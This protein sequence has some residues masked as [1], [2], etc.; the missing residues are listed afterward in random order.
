MNKFKKRIEKLIKHP[1]NA[2]VIGNGFGQLAELAE[3]FSTLFVFSWGTSNLKRKNIVTRENFSG[4]N[5][6]S[7]VCAII[8]DLD[9]IHHLSSMSE[10]W[11]RHKVLVLIEGNAPI[12]RDLSQSLYAAH[13]KCIDQHGFYHVWKQY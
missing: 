9:Q 1:K 11:Q 10:I 8:I 7:D 4:L 5:Q 2:I 13:F 12:E 3:V 6:L